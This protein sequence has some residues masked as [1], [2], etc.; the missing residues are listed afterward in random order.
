M[1]I[2]SIEAGGTK[3]VC[4]VGDEDYRIKDKQII[5]TTTPDE[6]LNAVIKYFEKFNIDALGV[7]SFGPIEIRKHSEKYGFITNTPKKGWENIDVLGRLNQQFSVPISWTT[8]VNGS[9]YGEYIVSTLHNE[10]ITSLVYYTVGTGVGAGAVINGDFLGNAGHPEMGHTFVKRHPEDENFSGICPFHQDCLEGLVSGP[11]FEARLNQKGETVSLDNPI[12]DKI[13]YYLAQAVI[14][15]TMVVR[16][17]KIIFGGSVVGEELLKKVREQFSELLN[18]YIELPP[19]DEYIT[20]PKVLSNGSATLG[21]IALG[22]R[23]AKN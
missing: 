16:P 9:A 18:D 5:P 2:G 12:W 21:N 4:A 17:D 20:L 14:Q 23:E 19:L 1:L 6:T 3:F 13:A 10:K 7:A 8:D 15:T 11:T 22:L